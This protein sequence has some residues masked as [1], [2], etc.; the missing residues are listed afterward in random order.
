MES[1][2]GNVELLSLQDGV[3]RISLQGSCSDCAASS[4]T[5]ELAIKQALE[6]A[7]PDLEG[8]EVEGVTPPTA[9]ADAADGGG[10][11][12]PPRAGLE[13]PIVHVGPPPAPPAWFELDG[14]DTLP[15]GRLARSP[16]PAASW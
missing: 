3:A 5:L 4:V 13:L 11:A 8:L 7:A 2:G 14:L 12:A 6:E 1:H 16:S 9:G 15:A 10:N